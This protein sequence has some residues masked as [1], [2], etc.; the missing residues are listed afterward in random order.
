VESNYVQNLHS[1]WRTGKTSL[2]SGERLLKSDLR[3]EDYGHIEE[4]SSVLGAIAP[5][6]KET[7]PELD[8]EIKRWQVGNACQ[9]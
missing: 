5:Y 4:L 3:I 6:L 2:F 7:K 8:K 9:Q 1:K